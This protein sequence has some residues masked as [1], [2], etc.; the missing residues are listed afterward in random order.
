[1]IPIYLRI[2]GHSHPYLFALLIGMLAATGSVRAATDIHYTLPQIMALET[3]P[4]G[5]VFEIVSRQKDAL[6]WAIP[7]VRKQATQLRQRFPGLEIAVVSHGAEQFALMTRKQSQYKGTH[8]AVADLVSQDNIQLHVCETYAGWKGV[9]AS[10][11]PDYVD[12]AP[13]GPAQINNYREL[14]YLVVLVKPPQ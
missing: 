9:S 8:K 5:V 11:F 7:Q 1:M 3:A 12:V 13:A 10:E 6:T 2:T 14:G 4:S